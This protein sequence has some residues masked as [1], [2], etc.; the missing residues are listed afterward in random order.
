MFMINA[1]DVIVIDFS[2]LY[3]DD[4]D[5]GFTQGGCAFPHHIEARG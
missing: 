4:N 5:G 1:E 2:C 3:V